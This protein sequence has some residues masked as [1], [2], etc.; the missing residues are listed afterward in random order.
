MQKNKK[1]L[2]I[3]NADWVNSVDMEKKVVK[4]VSNKNGFESFIWERINFSND[5]SVYLVQV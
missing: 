2:Y 4:F 3:F 1:S 5:G